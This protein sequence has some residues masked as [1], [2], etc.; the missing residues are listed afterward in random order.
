MSRPSLDDT[1]WSSSNVYELL[2]LLLFRRSLPPT[3]HANLFGILQ[4]SLAVR[5]SFS[6]EAPST[7]VIRHFRNPSPTAQHLAYPHRVLCCF[8]GFSLAPCVCRCELIELFAPHSFFTAMV[9]PSG[10][11]SCLLFLR[12][13]PNSEL[14]L[15]PSTQVFKRW[16]KSPSQNVPN[17]SLIHRFITK[18]AWLKPTPVKVQL[19]VSWV[20][21]DPG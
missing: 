19:Q 3:R 1:P 11:A 10:S 20:A 18:L 8:S 5:H 21:E 15:N 17:S 2:L 14:E 6:P 7:G 9:D 16:R 12:L 13:P 4:D